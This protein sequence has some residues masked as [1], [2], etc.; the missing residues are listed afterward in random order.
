MNV[1]S[2]QTRWIPIALAA[3]VFG[4]TTNAAD[5]DTAEITA[6]FHST[7]ID[8][9]SDLIF[10]SIIKA[11]DYFD[12]PL[13]PYYLYTS[14]HA[15][16][17]V[18]LY[19]ADAVEG[20][21]K[22]H[23]TVVNEAIARVDHVSSPHAVWNEKAKALFLYVHAPNAQTVYCHS[24]DGIHFEFGA[25]C[26][27]RDMINERID[28]KSKSASYARIYRYRIPEYR[29]TWTMTL[30]ASGSKNA[31]G[32]QN[33]AIVLC[34]SDNGI[35]W[36]VR[37]PLI[38]DGNGGQ[39]YKALDASWLPING[40]NYMVYALRSR[41]EEGTDRV[42]PVHLHISEGDAN[43]RD[44]T[45]LGIFYHAKSGYPDNGAARGPALIPFGDGARLLYEAG[46]NRAARVALLTLDDG[47]TYGIPPQ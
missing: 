13:A 35:E 45:H 7:L 4:P 34:T 28:F 46:Q 3:I 26:V 16:A 23:S 32:L 38:D 21:W 41:A 31:Q 11:D 25:V 39:T 14:P 43:W 44:W 40:R 20:P 2:T 8:D 17:D 27:T 12:S 36:T 18:R 5:W 22:F 42:E 9:G 6:T 47:A 37:R 29:N 10:P 1:L 33:N 30:T 19:T 24:R 15:G